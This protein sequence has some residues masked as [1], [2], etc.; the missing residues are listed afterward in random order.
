VATCSRAAGPPGQPAECDRIA[1]AQIEY[2]GNLRI[3]F[4]GDWIDWPRRY[5]SGRGDV[6]WV[7]FADAGRGWNVG[8]P[9]G[10]LTYGRGAFPGIATW[11]SDL[12]LGLDFAGVGIY[13]AKAVSAPNP[14]NF[15]VRLRHRF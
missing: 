4:A 14:V 13:A 3:D 15:F 10:S 11:R 8:Q 12:G 5:H 2:R 1:L 9:D 6:Q 7:F